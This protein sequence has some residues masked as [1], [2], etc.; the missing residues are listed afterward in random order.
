MTSLP[1]VMEEMPVGIVIRTAK[2]KPRPVRFWAYMWAQDD[3]AGDEH[4]HDR[5]PVVHTKW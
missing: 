3:E 1:M 4:W 5:V 2:E